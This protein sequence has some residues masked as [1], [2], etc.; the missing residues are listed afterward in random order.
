MSGRNIYYFGPAK[1]NSARNSIE[2]HK[3]K[4]QQTEPINSTGKSMKRPI[5]YNTNLEKKYM[6]ATNKNKFDFLRGVLFNE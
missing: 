1:Q 6:Y 5:K 3:Q 2:A 4:T